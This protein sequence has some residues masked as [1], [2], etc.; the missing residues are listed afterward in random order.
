MPGPLL[1]STNPFLK[2]YL[3]ETYYGGV[4]YVWCS[5]SFDSTVLDRYTAGANVPPSSNPADLLRLLGDA[6]RRKD[7][8]DQKIQAQ[9]A[10]YLSLAVEGE[11]SGK[12]TGQAL[13][14]ITYRVT[15]ASLDDWRPLLYIIPRTPL[16]VRVKAVPASQCAGLGPEFIVTDLQRPEFDVIEPPRA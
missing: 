2:F 9:K 6:V 8:H 14:D 3:Q 5:E 15:N 1:Y 16:G 4:H 10:S 11:R 7:M 13:E 12:I